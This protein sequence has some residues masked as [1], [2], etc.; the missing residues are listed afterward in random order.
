MEDELYTNQAA[1]SSHL[2]LIVCYPV[3]KWKCIGSFY[4]DFVK[5]NSRFD[6]NLKKLRRLVYF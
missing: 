6:K 4:P 1:G 2:V 5:A 3:T